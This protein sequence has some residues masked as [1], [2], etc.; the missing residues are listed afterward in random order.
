MLNPPAHTHAFHQV[1]EYQR[2]ME[3]MQVDF[4]QMLRDTLDNMHERLT[5]NDA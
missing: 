5:R 4:T 1:M 3:D 2:K